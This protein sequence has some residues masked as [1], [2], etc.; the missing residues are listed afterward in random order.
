MTAL[1]WAAK[2]G[3]EDVARLLLS[4]FGKVS[5]LLLLVV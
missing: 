3:H 2:H 1:M 5:I 4:L